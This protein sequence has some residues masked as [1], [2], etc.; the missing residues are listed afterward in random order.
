MSSTAP[1][2]RAWRMARRPSCRPVIPRR[3]A[4]V[5]ADHRA[6]A[7]LPAERLALQH[8]GAQPFRGAVH[9]GAEPGRDRRRRPPGRTPRRA[10]LTTPNARAMLDGCSGRPAPSGPSP[11]RPAAPLRRRPRSRIARPVGESGGCTPVGTPS[12]SRTSRISPARPPASGPTTCTASTVGVVVHAQSPSS[13]VTAPWNSSSRGPVGLVRTASAWPSSAAF[14]ATSSC[15]G[16]MPQ[17]TSRTR[18]AVGLDGAH[19]GE[20]LDAAARRQVDV[21]EHHGH[22]VAGDEEVVEPRHGVV[23]ACGHLDPV[24]ACVAAELGAHRRPRVL[25][26]DGQH[27]HGHHRR[28]STPDAVARPA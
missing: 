21:G 4:E 18:L 24:L 5:V 2:H 20:Q 25:V 27:E 13:S 19:R 8:D 14:D 17:S 10:S 12:R 15:W 9:R 7:G 3:E 1:N 28:G 16:W 23:A 11:G 22:R 26:T 6:R